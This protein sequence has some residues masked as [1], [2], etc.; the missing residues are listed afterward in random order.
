MCCWIHF[1]FEDAAA[2]EADVDAEGV[3][4]EVDDFMSFSEIVIHVFV[5]ININRLY[6]D[7][8]CV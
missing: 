6:N 1:L 8:R 4:Y 3:E 7:G 2:D 5:Y